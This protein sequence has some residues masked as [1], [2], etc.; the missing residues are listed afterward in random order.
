M[1]TTPRP[2]VVVVNYAS[3]D[4][5]ADA[6]RPFE[7]TSWTIVLVDC[8]SSAAER[9]RISELGAASGWRLV[10]PQVNLG[11]GAGVNAGVREA[12]QAGCDICLVLNP[13]ATI[14]PDTA[15]SLVA[16]VAADPSLLVAPVVRTSRGR[17]WFAGAVLDLGSGRTRAGAPS[18]PDDVP[19]ISGA[20]FAASAE[21]LV[22]LGGFAGD[23]F[24]Y[25]E[26][27]DLS[28]RWVRDG[29]R[30]ALRDDLTCVH[31]PGGTQEGTARAS[32]RGKSPLYHYYNTRNRLLFAA[33]NVDVRRWPGWLRATP[34]HTVEVL[35]RGGRRAIVR[36]PLRTLWPAVRGTVSGL[37]FLVAAAVAT[38]TNKR[39][40]FDGAR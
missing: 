15:D 33:R 27:I 34:P 10:L 16:D 31:D 39:G 30:L 28:V 2:A 9:E 12:R 38:R 35:L 19:W 7:S 21:R 37:R 3:A 29:G 1:L 32:D 4:L 22:E 26:D 13:D 23:Y 24:L 11:F 36:H 14:R 5:A 8:W 17:D 40:T 20:C 25:W 18:R 6:L